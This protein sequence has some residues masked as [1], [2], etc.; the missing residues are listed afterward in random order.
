VHEKH[1][2]KQSNAVALLFG[3]PS[4]HVTEY[5]TRSGAVPVNYSQ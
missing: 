4:I 5:L 1:R 3:Q 2:G